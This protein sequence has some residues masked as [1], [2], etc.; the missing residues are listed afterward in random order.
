MSFQS[1]SLKAI[2]ETKGAKFN[3]KWIRIKMKHQ[4]IPMEWPHE[5]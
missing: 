2:C 3:I 4:N 1:L 5:K